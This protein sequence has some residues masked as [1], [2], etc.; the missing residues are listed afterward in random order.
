M[1]F[2]T[3]KISLITSLWSFLSNFFK[4]LLKNYMKKNIFV[5]LSSKEHKFVNPIETKK[6]IIHVNNDV[7]SKIIKNDSFNVYHK[8]L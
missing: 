1:S 4:I 8:K 3:R 2:T 7:I 5:F 6:N